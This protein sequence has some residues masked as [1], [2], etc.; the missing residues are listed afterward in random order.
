MNAV[1]YLL[2][3]QVKNYLKDILH[4]PSKL[5]LYIFFIGFIVFVYINSLHKP[6]APQDFKDIR[7]LHGVF[8]GW[9]L[10]LGTPSAFAALKNGAS[11]F[12][13]PDVNFLFVSPVSPK[14]ILFY[15][16]LKQVTG[17]LFGFVFMAFYIGMLLDTFNITLGDVAVMIISTALFLFTVQVFSLLL[18]SVVNG[19]PKRAAAA[20]AAIYTLVGLN[21]LVVLLVFMKNGGAGSA[22]NAAISSPYLEYIPLAGWYKGAAFAFIAGNTVRAVVFTALNT[23]FL[24]LSIIL[25]VKTDVDYYEDVLENAEKRFEVM[26]AVKE[27][28]VYARDKDSMKRVKVGK[29]GIG[30]GCGADTFFYKHICEAKRRS[31]FVFVDKVTFIMLIVNLIACFIVRSVNG[32]HMSAGQIMLMSTG[33]SVYI[34]FFLNAAGD[35]TRELMKPY[36]YL[37]PEPPFKKLIWSSMTSIIK[38]AIDGI[39]VFPI[40]CIAVRANLLTAFLCILLYASFGFLFT[41][42]N[43]LSQR[44]FGSMSNR[45]V[46]MFL[47][48]FMSILIIAPGVAVSAV[49]YFLQPWLP[50][51][52]IGLPTA[53]W[54]VIVSVLI[55]Y[56]CRN[57][58]SFYADIG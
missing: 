45:G 7:M 28:R 46:T 8:L 56:A 22:L 34:L 39:I 54:N 25:F 5:I 30:K 3:K 44:I 48:I 50:G 16:L 47:Y 42:G 52:I 35:W 37:V 18:Y 24:I 32:G 41:A 49:L 51:I 11:V 1:G 38:P 57:L 31:R 40:T 20:K 26:R 17:I 33:I 14:K 27:K 29:E 13:M 4:H 43:V 21:V 53:A 10:F 15:G 55:F 2:R 6:S 36:I 19:K 23:A 9:L 12:K 58:L